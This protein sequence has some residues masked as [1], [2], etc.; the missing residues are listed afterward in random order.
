[1]TTLNI[2]EIALIG[3]SAIAAIIIYLSFFTVAENTYAII[4]S[5]GKY[6]RIAEPGFSFKNPL[7]EKIFKRISIQNNAMEIEFTATTIDQA[8]VDFKALVLY[9]VIDNSEANL[10]KVAFK[11][12]SE[13]GFTQ[14][15]IRSIEAAVRAYVATKKQN[16]ILGIRHEMAEHIKS[17]LDRNLS[18]W[19]Y[20]LIDLQINDILFD[21]AIMRSM[22]QVVSSENLKLAAYNEGEAILVKAQKKA[23]ADKIAIILKSEAQAKAEEVMADALAHSSKQL[24]TSG[25]DFGYMALIQ[26]MD[27]MK[28]IAEHSEGNV[29][30]MD[31][32]SEGMEKTLRQMQSLS[33]SKK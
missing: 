6:K 22:A 16:Q 10:K 3:V 15:L 1:M 26:W 5:F 30:F 8:N 20:H 27:G 2:I 11:F 17:L 14:A 25:L 28:H 9:A 18:D 4:T 12:Q 29:I 24:N 21:E 19:G 13:S 7:S 23:E 33:L 32:S 31:G